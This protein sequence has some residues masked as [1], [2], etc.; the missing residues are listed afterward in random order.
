MAVHVF[1]TFELTPSSALHILGDKM[2]P[3]KSLSNLIPISAA[4][5]HVEEPIMPVKEALPCADVHDIGDTGK[6]KA[7]LL[8]WLPM[9][10]LHT[11]TVSMHLACG[12]CRVRLD[13]ATDSD[14][15]FRRVNDTFGR[16]QGLTHRLCAV[17]HLAV[18]HNRETAGTTVA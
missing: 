5:V 14:G 2:A 11:R 15:T 1:D 8:C 18:D 17:P 9:V 12:A 3:D 16:I 13:L 4:K 6:H 10:L 7:D